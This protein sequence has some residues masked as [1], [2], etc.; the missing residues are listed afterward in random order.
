L[1]KLSW[2]TYFM[3]L[4]KAQNMLLG[5]A[6]GDAF[7]AGYEMQPRW[8]VLKYFTLNKYSRRKGW[9]AGKYTDDTQMT[10]ALVELLL[11]SEKFTKEAVADKF[12]EVYQRDP[13]G[14]YSGEMSKVMKSAKTGKDLIKSRKPGSP[15]N[16]AC[17]RVVPLGVLHNLS[18]VIEYAKTSAQVT[19]AGP[20]GETSAVCVAAASHYFYH[21]LGPP[22]GVFDYCINACKGMD[23]ES[24][25]YFKAVKEM[26]Y[27][28]PELL[29]G[30]KDRR[31][32][33][34]VDGMRTAG[35]VLYI[36]ARFSDDPRQTLIESVLLGGDTDS[37]TAIALGIVAINQGLGNIPKVLIDGLENE[38]FG[39]DYLIELGEKLQDLVVNK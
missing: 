21:N 25:E 31:F 9:K 8:K 33:V 36:L 34:P 24:I 26:K 12:V 5:I 10:I 2:G 30:E 11:S 17:M 39:K 15:G 22:Q 19:H 16:G 20:K 6:I 14:G 3:N 38:G 4:T 28:V 23:R 35:A 7:G 37:T 18:D 27:L 1:K 13:H 29:F 32:G